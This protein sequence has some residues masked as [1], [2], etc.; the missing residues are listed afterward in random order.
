MAIFGPKSWVNPFLKNLNFSTFSTFFYI[1]DRRFLFQNTAKHIPCLYCQ[2]KGGKMAIFGPKQWVNSLGKI[3]ISPL[4]QL[5]VFIAQKVVFS[6][7]N[8][9]KHIFPGYIAKKK[10]EMWPF[11]DQNHGLTSLEKSQF[12]EFLHFLF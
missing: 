8:I 3:S 4:F 7:Q 10:W 2:K 5:L 11:L 12:F 6:F 1:L 9:A